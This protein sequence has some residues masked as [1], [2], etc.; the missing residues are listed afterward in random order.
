MVGEAAA[1][2][3]PGEKTDL[4]EQVQQTAVQP[5]SRF[6]WG[7]RMTLVGHQHRDPR[8]PGLPRCLRAGGWRLVAAARVV[9]PVLCLLRI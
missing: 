8:G 7:L 4:S 5:S 2:L 1:F 6:S 9:R 3:L